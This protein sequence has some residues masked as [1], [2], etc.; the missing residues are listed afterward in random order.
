MTI[1]LVVLYPHPIDADEFERLYVGKHLPLMRELV[2]PGVPL[3]TYRTIGSG[4][5]QP[6]FYR[7]AEIH[8]RSM[9]HFNEFT[10]SGRS[11]IGHESSVK[12]STGG[13]PIYLVC[14]EQ[15]SI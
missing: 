11:K 10:G 6:P 5:R 1:K 15:E 3:P 7:V 9:D 12:V 13:K 4:E 8:F 2:G 14:E